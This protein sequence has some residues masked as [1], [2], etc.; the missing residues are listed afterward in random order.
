MRQPGTACHEGVR[1]N[2]TV[3]K[4]PEALLVG[5]GGEADGIANI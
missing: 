4:T 1:G 2:G 5:E 3:R